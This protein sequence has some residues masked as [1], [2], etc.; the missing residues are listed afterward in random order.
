MHLYGFYIVNDTYIVS[1]IS[2]LVNPLKR[3]LCQKRKEEG[4][5]EKGSFVRIKLWSGESKK[6]SVNGEFSSQY[7]L[8][9]SLKKVK[10][11]EI[12]L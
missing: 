6:C 4:K 7:T 2:R 11:I 10:L 5:K 9:P 3:K 12:W 1:A 8:L